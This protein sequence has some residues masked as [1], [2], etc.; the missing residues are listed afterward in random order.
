LGFISYLLSESC[1]SHSIFSRR[2][3]RSA[4]QDLCACTCGC[5]SSHVP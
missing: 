3:R 1:D 4:A 2:N 5:D